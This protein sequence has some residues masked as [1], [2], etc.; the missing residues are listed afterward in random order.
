MAVW[1]LIM[2]AHHGDMEAH[3]NAMGTTAGAVVTPLGAVDAQSGALEAHPEVE[4]GNSPCS[5]WR[6][7]PKK[8]G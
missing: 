3:H 2:A 7:A 1:R 5:Q 6:L 8:R 4:T